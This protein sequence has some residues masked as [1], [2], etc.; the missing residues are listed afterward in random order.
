MKVIRFVTYIL[1]TLVILFALFLIYFTVKDYK[2][3]PKKTLA[4]TEHVQAIKKDTLELLIWNIGYCGLSE[5]M[6]F[7]YDGGE[8][9]RTTRKQTL[10]NLKAVKDHLHQHSSLDFILLQEVD[11]ASKR[12]YFINENDSLN[13]A[14]KNHH[15]YFA[16]N[17]KVSYV[18]IPLSNPMGKVTSGLAS[19]SLYKPEKVIRHQFPGNYAWPKNLF[20]LD[21][22][23]LV[24]RYP[25]KNGEELLVINTHNSAYDDGALKET[26]MKNLRQF[27]TEE[28]NKGNYLIIG[29]D[30]NQYP[31]D[32]KRH[33]KSAQKFNLDKTSTIDRHYMPKEWEWAYDPGTATNRSLEKPLNEKTDKAVIDFYLLS[34]NI[35]L[36]EVNTQDLK[37]K[38]SDHQPVY[39]KVRL[40]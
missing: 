12:S 32:I 6:S 38:N 29:G 3:A 9:V 1:S 34:P 13:R 7:F 30:W 22:C 5:E 33:Q 8:K 11:K 25:L 15:S 17:Y 4:Q 27:I 10:D 18:P 19:F 39:L 21:R 2:P 40:Q 28:Y 31:P 24:S 37:F 20:M 23:F 16:L 35:E 36:V 26:Q 14:L